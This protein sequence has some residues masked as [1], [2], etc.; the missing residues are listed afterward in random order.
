M[1]SAKIK[2]RN[3]MFVMAVIIS[4]AAMIAPAQVTGPGTIGPASVFSAPSLSAEATDVLV[5]Q[6][7]LAVSQSTATYVSHHSGDALM[8]LNFSFPLRD[9]AGL[10]ALIEQESRTHQYLS[11]DQLYA[12]FAPPAEQVEAL[13]QWLEGKGFRV[14]RVGV[15]RM[16]VTAVAKT[17]V[18]ERVLQVAINDYVRPATTFQGLKVASYQFFANA[19]APVVPARLGLQSIS[20]LSDVDRFFTQA[21]IDSGDLNSTPGAA[22]CGED[23]AA[24]NPLCIDVRSGG[25]YPADLRGLYNITGHGFDGTGQTVGFTLWTAPERQAAMTAYATATGDVP[26]TIDPPC[27]ATGNSPT[28]PSSCASQTV[29]ADHLL[30]ILENGNTNSNSNYGSNVETALDIEAAHAIATHVGMKYYASECSATTP[31]GSGLTSAGC[32][33][34]DVGLEMAIE[35]AASDPT[36]HS[37]S[38]SWAFG[39]EAEWG[40]ADPFLVTAENSLALAAA[41]GTTFYFSTGDSGTYQSGYPSDSPHVVGVGGISTYSTSNPSTWST[42]ATWAGG[43]SWCSNVFARPSWQ[44]GD[45]V[46]ANAPC[47]GRVIPDVSAIADSSTGVRV[48]Y[49]NGSGGTSSGQVGGTSLAA[50]VMNALQ[51]VTQ[52]FVAVQTYPGATPPMGF[53]APVMYQMGNSANYASYFRDIECGNTANP[54]SGPDGEA[55]GKG[56]DAATGW[57]EPDWYNYSIG[58]ALTLGATNLSVP[59]SLSRGFGWTC[60]KTPSNSTERGFS[61]PTASVGY[62]VGNA[63]GSTPW[64]GKF[65]PS[66]AWGA[67]NTFFKTTDGGATWFPSNSDMFSIACTSGSMCIEVGAGGRARMTTDGGVTW[68]DV[69]TAAGNNKPLTQ[70]TCPDSSTCYAVGDRGNAM[71]ST[72]GGSTW[73]W[74]NTTDGNPL[75]GLSCPS[76][77][78]CYATDIYAHVLKTSDG[79]VT[80]TWQQ[81]PITTPGLQVPGSGGPNPFAGLMAISCSDTN[82]CVASGLYVVPSGQTIPSN[83]PPIVTTTDG[84]T[85]WIRQT[86]GA[87]TGS[88]LHSISCLPGTTTCFAVGRG[89]KIVTTTDLS[90]WT[91]ATSNTTNMLNSVTCLSESFCMAVGQNGTVD[92]FNGTTWTATTG[93]GGTGMLASVSCLDT[94]NCY[95]TGKQGVTIATTDGGATWTQ[96]AG[97]GTTQQMNSIS[98]PAADTCYAVGNAGTILKTSNGGQTWLPQPSGTTVALNGVACTSAMTCLAVGASGT[99]R[100][101]TDGS[102]WS[103]VTTGTTQALNGVSCSSAAACVAVGAAGTTLTSSNTGATWSPGVSGTTIALNA[104]TCPSATCYA[105]GA[106]TAGNAILI[107]STNNGANWSSQVSNSNNQAMNGIACVDSSNCFGDG[108]TGTVVGTTDGGATW[109]MRGNPLGGPTTALNATNIALNGAACTSARCVVGTGVQGDIM[110]TPLLHVAVHTS[111]QYGTTPNLTGLQPNNPA[112]SYDPASEAANVTGT[113]TCST[114]ATNASPVGSYSISGC[115]GLTGPGFSVVYDYAGSSHAVV[116]ADQAITFPAIADQTYGAADFDPGATASSGLAV[117]YSASGNC[118]IVSGKVHLTGAGSCTVTA[119]QPGDDNYNAAPDVSRTFSIAKAPTSMALS[120]NPSTVQYSDPTTLKAAITPSNISGDALTGSVE[121]FINGSSVGSAMVDSSGTAGLSVA[122]TYA[123]GSYSVTAQFTSTNGNFADSSGGP[124]TLT[125][126]QEDAGAFYNGNMLFWTSSVNSNSA[127]VTLSAAILDATALPTTDPRYDPNAGDIRNAKVTFI[128]EDKGQVLCSNLPV[129]LVSTGDTKTGIATCSTTLSVD[130][131]G[132]AQYTIGIVVSGYYT[133]NSAEDNTV[134][135]VAQPIPS[136]FITGGGFLALTNSSGLMPGDQGSKNNFG[137]NVTYNKK[138][139]NLQ[140]HLNIIVR[141]SGHVYQIKGNAVSSLGVINNQANFTGKSSIQDITD[142]LNPISIDGNA[143]VQMWMTDHGEPGTSDT[144]GIQVLDK[145]GG[146]WFSSN[147]SG[148]NTIEQNLGGGNLSVH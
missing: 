74:L 119:S 63:S 100:I 58:Y 31:P 49:T 66:G 142:P 146:M 42:S 102:T 79:G 80:W 73:S 24:I 34:S 14:T 138:G 52:N 59:P 141:S 144:I 55:A 16:S 38:N 127:N 57:G 48:Y 87:G 103:A 113:L 136:N 122:M 104:V 147:W 108:A 4:A 35:D 30:F 97:G 98:C 105:T 28:V 72:D 37:V 88:Y 84:G 123:P 40:A 5:G 8:T 106:V 112:L 109:T 41:A 11:R 145:N 107:K 67:V 110:T 132:A 20:G 129:G 44:T 18:V 61:F 51:A 126:T 121:F 137:F 36:L 116:K 64:Y 131:T 96:Q 130:N 95:A 117:S 13:K 46:T 1:L 148:T 9:K 93:N 81:T 33:G 56:W 94:N 140:G 90:T 3:L 120:A 114:T 86:S 65:L 85:T 83:D 7:P 89:G 118:S 47:P 19:T 92:I 75:Y 115:N 53:T 125:E 139:T 101:T 27:T 91:L 21:Q 22:D 134:I 39:G 68:S 43:G 6:V 54:A 10:D 26:I 143:T 111:S 17:S 23:N 99:A 78:V 76:T 77:S 12:R 128:N 70:V 25:Y 45:G 2:L 69:A 15:D 29:A 60:A 133:R 71:K 135:D 50:P 124:I 82:T 32:N 62:A